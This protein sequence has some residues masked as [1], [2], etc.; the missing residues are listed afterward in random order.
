VLSSLG[1][2]G[3]CLGKTII[4]SLK[5]LQ[6]G[7]ANLNRFAL[8]MIVCRKEM[9]FLGLTSA[10]PLC[11]GTYGAATAKN[12]IFEPFVY[13]NDDFAKTGSGQT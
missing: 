1:L 4:F 3:A 11:I 12:G 6:K 10:A 7:V 9:R 2:S 13:K 8:K 5:R